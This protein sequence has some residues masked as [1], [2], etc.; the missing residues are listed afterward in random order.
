MPQAPLRT[1][2]E[3]PPRPDVRRSRQ[4]SSGLQCVFEAH[5]GV[6]PIQHDRGIRQR[7]V[8][9]PPQSGIAVAKTVAGVSAVTPAIAS[10]CLNAPDAIAGLLRAK[11]KL[12]WLP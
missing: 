11:A 10:A 8:L 6:P 1:I 2:R 12:D 4:A 5:R 3:P 9:Q 7:L